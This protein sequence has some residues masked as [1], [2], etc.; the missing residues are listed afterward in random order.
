VTD[1]SI[2]WHSSSLS[3]ATES[4]DKTGDWF[5]EGAPAIVFARSAELGLESW[6]LALLLTISA[7]ASLRSSF[8]LFGALLTHRN[9]SEFGEE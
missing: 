3:K 2:P 1:P 5:A 6:S 4:H 9:V 8:L 7:F